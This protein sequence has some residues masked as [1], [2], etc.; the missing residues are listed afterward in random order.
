MSATLVA[1]IVTDAGV[2]RGLGALYFP[3][4]SMIPTVAFPW[5]TPFTD[6][7]TDWFIFPVTEAENWVLSPERSVAFEGVTVM[8]LEVESGAARVQAAAAARPGQHDQQKER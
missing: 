2:G 3:V 1:L 4:A 6:Q 5:S 7:V 8:P